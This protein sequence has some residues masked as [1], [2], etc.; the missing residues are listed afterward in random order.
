MAR[1][2]STNP[3]FNWSTTGRPGGTYRFSVWVKNSSGA[4]VYSNSLGSYD[5]FNVNQY[6]TLQ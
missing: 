2:Y 1:D 4:G 5:A 3:T 6:Y